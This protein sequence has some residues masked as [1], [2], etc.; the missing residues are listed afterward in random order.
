MYIYIYCYAE[1]WPEGVETPVFLVPSYGCPMN[2]IRL[3][4]G[5]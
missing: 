5:K 3:V 2:S 1:L 4:C